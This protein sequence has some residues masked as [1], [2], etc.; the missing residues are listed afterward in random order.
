MPLA[1]EAEESWEAPESRSHRGLRQSWERAE[2]LC[3]TSRLRMIHGRLVLCPVCTQALAQCL[4]HVPR[5][6]G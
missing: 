6:H 1:T 5:F 2:I 4:G 3:P